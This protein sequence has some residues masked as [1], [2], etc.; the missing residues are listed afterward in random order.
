[1]CRGEV[2]YMKKT[3]I[4]LLLLVLL[5]MP[6]CG[7]V[8]YGTEPVK[9]FDVSVKGEFR[10]LSEEESS[11]LRS[12]WKEADWESGNTKTI[13]DY[14]FKLEEF[15]IRYTSE[16][17]LF[18]DVTHHRHYKVTEEQRDYINSVICSQGENRND[19]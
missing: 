19:P 3:Y 18:N 11:Y 6:A 9:L 4:F 10:E 8:D 1:M 17:G 12:V 5:I 2:V 13:Y 16:Q 14:V 7:K 15:S